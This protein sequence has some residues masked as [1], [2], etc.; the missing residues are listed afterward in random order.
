MG[1]RARFTQRST[2]CDIVF[3]CEDGFIGVCNDTA[4]YSELAGSTGPLVRGADG[5][6]RDQ[7]ISVL[8]FRAQG[9]SMRVCRRIFE[10]SISTE[11]LQTL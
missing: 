10:A 3:D 6:V 7:L 9:R 8:M 5:D 1:G 2:Y 11:H 4:V